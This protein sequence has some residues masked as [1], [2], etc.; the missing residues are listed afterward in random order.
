MK[1]ELPE[2]N[3]DDEAEPWNLETISGDSL[4]DVLPKTPN[5]IVTDEHALVGSDPSQLVGSMNVL[6]LDI[7]KAISVMQLHTF[8]LV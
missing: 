2:N 6:G 5:L 4:K 8:G 1:L 3:T 7:E